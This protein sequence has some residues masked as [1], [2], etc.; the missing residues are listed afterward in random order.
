PGEL[1]L[2]PRDVGLY[3]GGLTPC[4]PYLSHAAA[5][6]YDERERAVREFYDPVTPSAS[7]GALLSRVCPAYVVLPPRLPAGWL[8]DNGA[9]RPRLPAQGTAALAAWSR[10]PTRPCP[11]RGPAVFR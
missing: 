1:V 9:Y 4:W 10:D 7:R 11:G 6:E 2:A 5:P 3:V 8:G